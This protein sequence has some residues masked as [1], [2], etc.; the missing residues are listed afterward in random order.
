M[1]FSFYVTDIET[2]GLDSHLHDVIELSM[3]R[4]GDTTE[5]A[6]MTWCI[7]PLTPET[8]DP[9]ALRINGH[10]LEDI[11]HKTKEGRERYREAS[12]VLVDVENWMALDG[13]PAEKRFLIGQNVGFDKDR[14]EMLWIK[15]NSKDSFPI[16]RRVMD[17]MI[18]ELFFDFCKGEF[19]EGYSLNQ[20][21]K[22]YGIKNEKAHTAAAD[23]KATKEVFEKQV[24]YFKRL[25]VDSKMMTANTGV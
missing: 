21:I 22:K 5:T 2:T 19:A 4:L 3:Y 8:A 17:T 20:I 25:L 1:N 14:L 11:T 18:M 15:C 13:M 24:E 16:G 6:Q 12:S 9:V 10:K 7:K 23:V